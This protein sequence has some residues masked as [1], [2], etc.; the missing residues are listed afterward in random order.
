MLDRKNK[1]L[2]DIV[3]ILEVYRDNV[4]VGGGQQEEGAMSQREI[5]E[6]LIRFLDAA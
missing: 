2:K 4:D 3:K 6:N 5:L 1:S